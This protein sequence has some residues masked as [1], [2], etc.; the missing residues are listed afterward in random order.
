MLQA[1]IAGQGLALACGALARRRPRKILQL[2][3][4]SAGRRCGAARHRLPRP[5]AGPSGRDGNE[6]IQQRRIGA[7]RFRFESAAEAAKLPPHC[8]R[9]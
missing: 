3:R 7:K 9:A 2:H 6:L 1:A 5:A 4:L 8:N